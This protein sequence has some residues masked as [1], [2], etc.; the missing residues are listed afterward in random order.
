MVHWHWNH[1]ELDLKSVSEHF[2]ACGGSME[3]QLKRSKLFYTVPIY[4]IF[5]YSVPNLLTIIHFA[6][7]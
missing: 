3:R 5:V 4:F 1:G 6:G 7:Q 2:Q